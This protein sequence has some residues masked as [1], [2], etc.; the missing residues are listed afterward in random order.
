MVSG[1]IRIRCTLPGA[2]VVWLVDDLTRYSA[3]FDLTP[4]TTTG[5]RAVDSAVVAHTGDGRTTVYAYTATGDLAATTPQGLDTKY[6]K[7]KRLLRYADQVWC[8]DRYLNI[9][10]ATLGGLDPLRGQTVVPA[11]IVCAVTDV[12]WHDAKGRPLE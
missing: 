11:P 12:R 1:L 4:P 2:G 5:S 9:A 6:F 3:P 7:T 10:G 8:A